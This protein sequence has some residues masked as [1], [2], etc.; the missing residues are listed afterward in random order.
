MTWNTSSLCLPHSPKAL[1]NPHITFKQKEPRNPA[2]MAGN[3]VVIPA[4]TACIYFNS[5]CGKFANMRELK[6]VSSI[7]CLAYAQ[8][9]S[10]SS[11]GSSSRRRSRSGSSSTSNSSASNYSTTSTSTATG[12]G[13]VINRLIAMG[14]GGW[15]RMLT[16][17]ILQKQRS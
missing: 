1:T 8:T 10:T 3:V 16:V 4:I 5:I 14:G 12:R 2:K 15:W 6:P 9:S 7:V 13:E 11:T 17:C